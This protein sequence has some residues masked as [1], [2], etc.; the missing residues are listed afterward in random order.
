M[1]VGNPESY[2]QRGLHQK[3]YGQQ[4][5]EG[6]STAPLCSGETPLGVLCPALESSV[7]G[8]GPIGVGP[9]KNQKNYQRAGAP[10]LQGKSERVG[11]VQAEE[12]ISHCNVSL[13]HCREGV[14]VFLHKKDGDKLFSKTCY[15]MRYYHLI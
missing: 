8:Q 2:S 11:V 5:R 1:L 4:V 6:S 9:E 7:Q 12:E 3:I 14:E 15:N 10:L 13:L